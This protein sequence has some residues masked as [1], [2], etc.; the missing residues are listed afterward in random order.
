MVKKFLSDIPW[1]NDASAALN[2]S[3]TTFKNTQAT[4]KATTCSQLWE[5]W[6][7]KKKRP[8]ILMQNEPANSILWSKN[9]CRTYP[10]EMTHPRHL[11]QVLRHSKTPRLRPKLPRAVNYGKNGLKKKK[12]HVFLCRM[13]RRIRFYGQKILVGHTLGK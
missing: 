13:S 6:P 5:K 8:C 9:S 7:K 10:G 12:D 1:G 3:V 2:T 11:I 4:A